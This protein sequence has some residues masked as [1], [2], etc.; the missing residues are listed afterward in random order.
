[1][2][3]T[4][5]EK[6]WMDGELVDWEQAKIHVLTHSL[7][8]GLGVFEGIRAYSTS[9]GP[10]VFRLTDHIAR[11]FSGAHILGMKVPFS[12][13]EMIEA[14]KT[15]VL[16]NGLEACYIRPIV[17]LGYGEMGL[18]PM[19]CSVNVAVACWPWGAYLGDEGVA[20]GIR[21]KVSSW[22]RHDSRAM[23]TAAKG[24]GMYVNSSLAKVEAVM[25]GYDEALLLTT[26]GHVCEG[27]GENIFVVRH[28]R[29]LTPPA[30][31]VGALEGITSDSVRVI[32]GDLGYEV[33]E[34]QLRRTDLYMGEEAWLTGT[35]AEVVPVTSVDDRVVGTGKPGPITKA[36]QEQFFQAV[37]G[38]ID[39]YK[40]WVEHVT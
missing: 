9:Q 20:N 3:L 40:D 31:S 24:T 36:I 21:L 34:A 27:T 12:P 15:V 38:Q 35:A 18:N 8:Y 17:Y 22:A 14:V 33:A 30:S 13:E 25:A 6:I 39:R 29:I 16:V 4:P 37:R 5:T 10:A 26:D 28:G 1:M 19:L 11:L 7:H 32:A 23:P 2:P